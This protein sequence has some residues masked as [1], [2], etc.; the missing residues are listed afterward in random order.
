MSARNRKYDI[1]LSYR[2]DGGAE[3]A[4][5]LRDTLTER[6]YSVFLDVESLRAGAFN[7]EL[8]RVIEHCTDFLLI[9]PQNGLDRCADEGDWIRLEIEH[10][11][12]NRKNI[13]PIMLKGF[14]FPETLPESIDFIRTQNG[15]IATDMAYYDAYVDRLMEFLQSKPWPKWKRR[16][17][18]ISTLT[19]A[20]VIAVIVYFCSTIYPLTAS[21]SNLVSSLISYMVL[22]L[23]QV[24]LAGA[25]YVKELDRAIS[26]VEG[27]TTD[28]ST[29]VQY[30]LHTY[31]KEISKRGDSITNLPDQLRSQLMK[32]KKF[33]VG[34]LDAF[35]PAL[36]NTIDE[37][38]ENI[39]HIRD[40]IIGNEELRTEHMA[41][42]F[43]VLKEMA[44]LDAEMLFYHL[45]ETLLPVTNEKALEELKNDMLPQMTFLYSGRWEFTHDNEA[46][47]GKEEAIYRQ[48]EALITRY[49]E[50]VEKEKKYIDE[51]RL[52]S[53]IEKIVETMK[54]RGEDTSVIEAKLQS[55][56]EAQQKLE[57]TKTE[58]IKKDKELEQKKNELYEKFKPLEDDSQSTLW[59]KGVKFLTVNMPEAAEEC[60]TI[61]VKNA[62]D[63]QRIYGTS[64][65]K[66]AENYTMLCEE[67][68]IGGVV[69]CQYEEGRPR[70]AVELGDIIYAV[71]GNVI[72]NFSEYG[73]AIEGEEMC[74][75]N[76]LR[77]TDS[78]YELVESVVESELGKIGMQ[79]LIEE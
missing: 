49:A 60:F 23:N 63:S 57:E 79:G 7:T 3:T 55:I 39:D 22:N 64:A 59:G 68:I 46:L 54:E 31:R 73:S 65:K 77:F 17:A 1:F 30:E 50:S 8:Y 36:T 71:D 12:K 69:V 19:V 11:K 74:S 61:Y 21:Q 5:H 75:I 37:Y 32:T 9:L 16:A 24:D 53:R 29:D 14:E 67:G 35:K 47:V 62:D 18:A 28:S 33:D 43:G 40:N 6:G 25:R 26:Y 44:E 66:F 70:Q 51:T 45:N 48:Y 56:R 58:V 13:V 52:I 38:A 76:I 15:P 34:D 42:Y 78:G 41:E 10:A 27:K 72:H 20:V 4:K 2:R